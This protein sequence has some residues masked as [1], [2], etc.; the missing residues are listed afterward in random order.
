MSER[1]AQAAIRDSAVNRVLGCN[2][3]ENSYLGNSMS[4]VA[5]CTDHTLGYKLDDTLLGGAAKVSLLMGEYGTRR[6]DQNISNALSEDLSPA[7]V[8]N[9]ISCAFAALALCFSFLACACTSIPL[10]AVSPSVQR[11]SLILGRERL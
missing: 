5:Y 3:P 4:T 6:N 9:P 10:E 7:L 11:C 2:G 1:L 8:M